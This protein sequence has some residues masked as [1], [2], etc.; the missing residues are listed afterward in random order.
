MTFEEIVR[1]RRSVRIYDPE[2][3]LDTGKVRHCLELASL[4]PN[5]SNMQ[6]WEFYHVTSPDVLQAISRACLDQSSA[7]TAMEIVVFVTRQDLYRKRSRA[8]LAYEIE[9]IEKFS[10]A[11]R[12]AARIKNRKLYYGFLMPFI[13]A[14]FFGLLGWIRK[15]VTF[16]TGFFRP[17]TRQMTEAEMKAV[18]HKS[19]AL[20]AQTFM[21]AMAAEGYDTCPLEGFDSRLMKR[22]LKLPAGAE[23]N[24]V[25]PCG[26]RKPEGVRDVQ[27]RLPFEEIYNKV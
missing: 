18:V 15:F 26:T 2:K 6:L 9:A 19:C 23:I 5:S 25:I 24:M 12:K 21:L 1:Y 27:I 14:R 7:K 22:I 16:L 3:P 11:E 20:A 13:Y 10:P 8:M 17:I 4:A